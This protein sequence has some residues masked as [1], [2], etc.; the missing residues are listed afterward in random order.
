MAWT[1]TQP[2]L[3]HRLRDVSDQ[4][5]WQRFDER[6]GSLI[7]SY[8]R[9]RGLDLLDAEDVRQ[10]VLMSLVRALPSFEFQPERG[11]F[12]SYLGRAVGNAIERYRNRP[13]LRRELLVEDEQ[14]WFAIPA[15][16]TVDRTWEQEWQNHH[17]R[18]ALETIRRTLDPR[19]VAVFE[20]LLA[21]TSPAEVAE[22][23]AMTAAAV[24]KI[25]QRVRDRLKRQIARQVAEESTLD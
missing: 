24:H 19:H 10:I 16:D 12:R 8:A 22:E 3:L 6:Y 23:E 4:Q 7:V 17:L 20:R 14:A 13:F 1:T 15:P 9:R 18:R 5:A 11:R 2:S 21:G 25:K